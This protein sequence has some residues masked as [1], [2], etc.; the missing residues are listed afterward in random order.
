MKTETLSQVDL[1]FIVDTTGSMGSFIN[2]ARRRVAA[3]L[4]AALEAAPLTIDLRV[5]V[6]EYRDHPPQDQTFVARAHAFAAD[7]RQVQKTIA[8]LQP[9]GGGDAPE[10]VFDGLV[11]ACRD[12][13]WPAHR[14]RLA[15]RIGDAPPPGG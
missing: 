12:L 6:V 1:A 5:A 10:A 11:A 9:A 14:C 13:E 4:R 3:V 2:E 15:L 7:L 8:A